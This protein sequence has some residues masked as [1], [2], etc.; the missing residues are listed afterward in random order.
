MAVDDTL[1]MDHDLMRAVSEDV[2]D[3]SLALATMQ[4]YSTGDGL[5]VE[6]FG[7]THVGNA[8]FNAYNGAAQRLAAS[9]GKAHDFLVAASQKL[10]QTSAMVKETDV[11]S[12]WGITK[13]GGK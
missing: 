5:K 6:H 9:L 10:S 1:K 2:A 4:Q 12:A 3:L 8:A 13:A 7:G 11:D